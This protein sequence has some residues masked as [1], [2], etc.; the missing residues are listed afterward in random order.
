MRKGRR[1]AFRAAANR[2]Q[3][4]SD[5]IDAR[6]RDLLVQLHRT[7]NVKRSR[8]ERDLAQKSLSQ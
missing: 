4:P 8:H 6:V 3:Y 2:R 1:H 7:Q 5:E